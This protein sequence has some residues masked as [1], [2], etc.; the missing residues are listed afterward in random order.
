[1]QGGFPRLGR[2]KTE[3]VPLGLMPKGTGP[4]LGEV[5]SS[6]EKQG[7]F[8]GTRG[9]GLGSQRQVDGQRR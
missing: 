9:S 5:L 4:P 6:E 1:M 8:P 2:W 3:P 7:V